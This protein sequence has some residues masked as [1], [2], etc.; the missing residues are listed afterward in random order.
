MLDDPGLY[1]SKLMDV[2][3]LQPNGPHTLPV[4]KATMVHH[5]TLQSVILPTFQTPRKTAC[6]SHVPVCWPECFQ[7][8]CGVKGRWCWAIVCYSPGSL[9]R[10]STHN[11]Q[12]EQ[13]YLQSCHAGLKSPLG[14]PA[15]AWGNELG[16]SWP[17]TVHGQR[18]RRCTK[19]SATRPAMFVRPA[20]RGWDEWSWTQAQFYCC[21]GERNNKRVPCA[22]P[23]FYCP[24][25]EANFARVALDVWCVDDQGNAPE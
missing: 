15:Y 11:P 9:S 16:K 6:C 17:N 2:P 18:A 3:V 24:W 4:T 19:T 1:K 23:S 8:N 14:W 21:I 10:I 20:S 13:N 12:C 22:L 5:L 25:W 7:R